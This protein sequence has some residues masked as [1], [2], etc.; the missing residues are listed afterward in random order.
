[1]GWHIPIWVLRQKTSKTGFKTG[2]R[3][4][5]HSACIDLSLFFVGKEKINNPA[6]LQQ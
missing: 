1:M 6:G 2:R 5:Q 4:R 3:V